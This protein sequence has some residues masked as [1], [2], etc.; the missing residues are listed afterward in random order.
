MGN[1]HCH[2]HIRLRGTQVVVVLCVILYMCVSTCECIYV[3]LRCVT[4][5]M[6]HLKAQWTRGDMTS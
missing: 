5:V 2:R 4:K 1:Y 3:L 6:N